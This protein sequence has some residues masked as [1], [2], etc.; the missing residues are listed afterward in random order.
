VKGNKVVDGQSVFTFS[1]GGVPLAGKG[2]KKRKN[3]P[4]SW[5]CSVDKMTMKK[6]GLYVFDGSRRLWKDDMMMP[7]EVEVRVEEFSNGTF[8]T[9]LDV[10]TISKAEAVH[11]STEEEKGP[12]LP[13]PGEESLEELMA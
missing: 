3:Y 2:R 13:S 12:Y 5:G 6:R 4:P 1:K 8:S 10:L 7:R 9:D 11:N